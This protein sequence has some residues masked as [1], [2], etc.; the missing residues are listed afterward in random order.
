MRIYTITEAD[1]AVETI[2]FRADDNRFVPIYAIVHRVKPPKLNSAKTSILNQQEL[3]TLHSA[4]HK[5]EE[6]LKKK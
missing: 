1:N 6:L 3:A 5:E 4:I 2:E